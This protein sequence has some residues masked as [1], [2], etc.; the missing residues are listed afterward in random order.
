MDGVSAEI[1]HSGVQQNEPPGGL[2][3][4]GYFA[5]CI[6]TAIARYSSVYHG[7][8]FTTNVPLFRR[9]SGP[10]QQ[11]RSESTQSVAQQL[12]TAHSIRSIFE[13]ACTAALTPSHTVYAS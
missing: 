5:P 13:C 6:R 4:Y 3:Q 9:P 2:P 10:Q 11:K 8:C 7:R 12:C 1:Y